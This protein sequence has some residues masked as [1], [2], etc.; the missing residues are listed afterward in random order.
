MSN[1]EFETYVALMGKLL[2][3][4]PEQRE[5]ISGELQDHLQ[6]R[7]ADL[8][9]DGM[10][11]SDAVK[12]A[13]EE[14][15]DAAVMAK[16]FQTVLNLKRRRWMMRFATISMAGAFLAAVLTMAMWPDNSRF[17]SPNKSLAQVEEGAADQALKTDDQPVLSEATQRTRHAEEVLKQNISLQ[18]DEQPFQE[19]ELELEQRTGLNFILSNSAQDDSLGGD[20]PVTFNLVD[21]PLGKALQLMLRTKNA[22]Y[23]IEDGV[24]VIISLD[25]A[26]DVNYFRLKMY[27]CR[28]LVKALP[29]TGG[30][31]STGI[32][33]GVIGVVG[34]QGG[35]KG[36][37]MFSIPP[38]GIQ[39]NNANPA[40]LTDSE[41]LDEKLEKIYQL[42]QEDA[43]RKTIPPTSENTLL[44]LVQEMIQPDTWHDMGGGMGTVECVNGILVVNQT[45]EILQQID[46]F[47]ADL[48]G[49]I[50]RKGSGLKV[51]LGATTLR[52]IKS[53]IPGN[54]NTRP[55]K[56]AA[57]DKDNPFG[58]PESTDGEDPFK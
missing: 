19:I 49:N 15:G 9:E 46:N 39:S 28:E 27:D 44:S 26:S 8:V 25:D 52:E 36:G 7:V 56:T 30:G 37:G 3:L 4:T 35:G 5:Q 58:S 22:T 23:V 47:V 31:I 41:L 50:L 16:N 24:V 2:Q 29:K 45:E 20:E 6:M 12:Q 34:G 38:Q 53:S 55:K 32:V 51:E 21:M 57:V 18:Y 43:R 42:M 13:V 10:T 40:K 11:K 14:F 48:E 17:G 33:G 1:E 54:R